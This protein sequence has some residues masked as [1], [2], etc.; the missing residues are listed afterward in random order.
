ME[1]GLAREVQPME[2]G[3]IGARDA[4]SGG[5]WLGARGTA[6]GGGGDLGVRRS[7]RGGCGFGT[8]AGRQ[9]TPVLGPTCRQSL[10]CGGAS[11]RQPWIRSRTDNDC[12]FPLLRALS[13]CLTPQEWLPGESLV[14]APL[15][16]TDSGNGFSVASLLEDVV[17]ASPR[18]RCHLCS[19]VGLA[20]AGSMLAFSRVVC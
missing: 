12:S 7:C 9:G 13:C 16:P 1:A 20:A 10:S 8:K 17:L 6:G 3:L 14:L 15:S 2:G 19:F 5:G 4:S 11:V 18:G